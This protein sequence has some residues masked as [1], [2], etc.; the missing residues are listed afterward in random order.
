M[1]STYKSRACPVCCDGQYH[2]NVGGGKQVRIPKVA[3][4]ILASTVNSRDGQRAQKSSGSLA[5]CTDCLAKILDGGSLPKKL[6]EGLAAALNKM[7]VQVQRA[8]PLKIASRKVKK[9]K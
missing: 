7:E 8:L 1:G 6:R 2:W 3:L 4:L 5:M 9:S